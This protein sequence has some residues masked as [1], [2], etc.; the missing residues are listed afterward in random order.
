MRG[1]GSASGSGSGWT[2]AEE[3]AVAADES[4]GSWVGRWVT[5]GG[6]WN[7]LADD[8]ES[9]LHS[10]TSTFW[11]IGLG[12]SPET[13]SKNAGS[14]KSPELAC[15]FGVLGAAGIDCSLAILYHAYSLT[16][17]IGK[18]ARCGWLVSYL[19]E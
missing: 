1:S 11:A 6:P 18:G 7:P 10:Y 16:H 5:E 8:V 3:A 12:E 19:S 9:G 4:S 17:C 2:A 13:R 15:S 14:Y